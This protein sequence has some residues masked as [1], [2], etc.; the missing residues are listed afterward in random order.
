MYN[1]LSFKSSG[2]RYVLISYWRCSQLKFHTYF[3]ILWMRKLGPGKEIYTNLK[4][5]ARLIHMGDITSKPVV[6]LDLLLPAS[7]GWGKVIVSV[8]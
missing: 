6:S 2:E 7:V 5:Q 1:T 8:F 4:V 3:Q